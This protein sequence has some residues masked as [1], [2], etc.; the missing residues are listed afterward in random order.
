MNAPFTVR[1][2]A[3]YGRVD[4]AIPGTVTLMQMGEQGSPYASIL[5]S[6]LVS[7]A[8]AA[9]GNLNLLA[10]LSQIVFGFDQGAGA[11]VLSVVNGQLSVAPSLL[12]STV[13]ATFVNAAS[14][15]VNGAPVATQT[16]LAS[17]RAA[18]VTSFNQRTG[19]I[20][21]E[22][23]DILRAGGAPQRDPHFTGWVTAPSVWDTRQNDDTVATTNW[24]QRLLCTSLPLTTAQLNAIYAVP[25]PPYPMV[26]SPA[27]GDASSRIATTAFVDDTLVDYAPLQSPQFTGIPT[28][29]T[30]PVGD[31]SIRLATTA[32]VAS[33]INSVTAYQVNVKAFG[34]LGNAVYPGNSGAHLKNVT[35]NGTNV[36]TVSSTTGVSVGQNIASANWNSLGSAALPMPTTVTAVTPTTITV[37]QVIPTG[38]YSLLATWWPIN[39]TTVTGND[40]TAAIKAAIDFALQN[41]IPDVYLP[42]GTYKISDT[43]QLG[44]GNNTYSIHLIGSDRPPYAVG[45][46]GSLIV[47]V[48]PDRPAINVQQGRYTLVKGLHILGP[49]ANF[50]LQAQNYSYNL[51]PNPL[52]WLDPLLY[53]TGSTPGGLQQHTPLAGITIDAFSGAAPAA[54]YPQNYPAWTGLTGTY[55]RGYSSDTT[56]RECFV[57]GFGVNIASGLN[58]S[59][60]GD[61]LRVIGG[62]SGNAPYGTCVGNSQSRNVFIESHNF[63]G[64]NTFIDN[65]AMGMQQGTMIGTVANCSGSSLYRLLNINT[66]NSG[67]V[68]VANCYAE[69][70]VRIGAINFATGV[71]A[72]VEFDGCQFNFTEVNSHGQIPNGY[73]LVTGNGGISFLNS[74]ISGNGRINTFAAVSSGGNWVGYLT[75]RDSNFYSMATNGPGGS[76]AMQSAINYSGGMLPGPS[77]YSSTFT[78]NTY[79][80]NAIMP[81]YPNTTGGSSVR[82]DGDDFN[83]M[84]LARLWMT[85]V[86]K[87]FVDTGNKRW[88]FQRPNEG[89]LQLSV[90]PGWVTVAP[91]WTQDVVTFT[92]AAGTY[93]NAAYKI[94]PGWILHHYNSGTI[95]VVT[96]VGAVDGSGNYPITAVQQNNL[97]VDPVTGNYVANTL[98]DA[99]PGFPSPLGGNT[100]AIQATMIIPRQVYYGS[101]TN[102]S[103]AIATVHRGD[104]VA[105]DI[106][107]YLVVGDPVWA[108]VYQDQT[109][110]TWPLNSGATMQT[111][112]TVVSGSPGSATLSGNA[113]Q[114][115]RFPIYPIPI[116]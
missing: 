97:I 74:R 114:T 24:V 93:S 36:L 69:N 64:L 83:F 38:T 45:F 100:Q 109:N 70:A 113:A 51:S 115:G 65:M 107:T 29:P 47:S 96:A 106:A 80:Q 31:S 27:L 66:G 73:V 61:F 19:D 112:A 87:R 4:A 7:S 11:V 15:T 33:E 105:T 90:M 13:N 48:A 104:N 40:D 20:M 71:T 26:P 52:D 28:A 111:L 23:V 102:G 88:T 16:D 79:Y 58:T 101:F 10:G 8:L 46:A 3:Q 54:P 21:L 18:S 43:L 2:L 55:G 92:M 25:G 22:D 72:S 91:V 5:T 86:A 17:S 75:V 81:Y 1:Q 34:A 32:F 76:A 108:A 56:I 95:F 85:P 39:N 98:P 84:G 68:R 53:V 42:P 6:D 57:Q 94:L 12:T 103:N 110:P 50:A 78:D 41:N 99:A 44:Y 67:P 9:G 14:V 35:A 49:N 63:F 60:Q 82:I 116:R 59:N 30:P 89:N 77:R 62:L 37:S